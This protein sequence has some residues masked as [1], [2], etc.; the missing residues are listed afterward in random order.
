MGVKLKENKGITLV[1]LVI[2]IIVMLILV[3]VTVTVSLNSGLFETTKKARQLTLLARDQ[4]QI[5][6]LITLAK[7]TD[8]KATANDLEGFEPV[9]NGYYRGE[10]GLEVYIDENGMIQI[11][12]DVN[13]DGSVN[14]KDIEDLKK[15]LT[16]N[17]VEINEKNADLNFDGIVS[18]KDS[19][20][21]KKLLYEV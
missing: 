12:G 21:L 19:L 9:E 2:T 1:A 7:H 10:S 5:S 4:E 15:Y 20:L 16:A 17:N 6:P 13:A 8:Y 3:A 11:V 14:T 18:I